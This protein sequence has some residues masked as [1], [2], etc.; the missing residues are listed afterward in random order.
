M[1]MPPIGL[2][3]WPLR[4]GEA[5]RVVAEALALGYRHIDT[6][7]MYGNEGDVGAGIAAANLPREDLYVV[8]KVHQDRFGEDR[9]M[10]SA[11]DSLRAL[12]CDYLDLLLVHWPPKDVAVER[13]VEQLEAVRE[14]G[15]CRAIGVSN[16]TR[17]QLRAA[18]SVAR[19]ETNQVE[20]HLLIDQAPLKAEADSLGISLTAYMPVARGKAFQPEAVYEV[21]VKLGATP[22]QVALAWI[23]AMGVIPIPMSTKP[24]NL[25]SN[26]AAMDLEIP[27]DDLVRL[28]ALTAGHQRFCRHATWEPD[29]DA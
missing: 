10:A 1:N 21:A 23:V 19:I 16:F 15:I 11:E 14:A 6:A 17:P 22:P 29:W 9:V 4:E 3:T 2:G 24:A 5:E 28:T 12:D 18:A 27:P 26:L 7:Q 25:A 13:V 8:T 20:Y